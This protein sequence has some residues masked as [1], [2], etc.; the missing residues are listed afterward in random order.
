MRITRRLLRRRDAVNKETQNGNG[1][2]RNRVLA[3]L[4]HASVL[5]SIFVDGPSFPMLGCREQAISL[6]EDG[7][8]GRLGV[9]Q[10]YGDF[11]P[12]TRVLKGAC[13]PCR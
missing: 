7:R 8:A 4:F 5:R 2:Q 12:I 11:S 6:I 9:N 13:S 1:S 10:C 3:R